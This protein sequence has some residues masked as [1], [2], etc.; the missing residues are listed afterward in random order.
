MISYQ[1]FL[2]LLSIFDV[3]WGRRSKIFHGIKDGGARAVAINDPSKAISYHGNTIFNVNDPSNE[4]DGGHEHNADA[5]FYDDSTTHIGGSDLQTIIEI[6]NETPGTPGPPGPPGPPGEDGAPGADGHSPVLT[7]ISDQI[8]IDGSV[9]GPHLTGPPGDPASN[10]H[11]GVFIT[12]ITPTGAGNVG[13]KV[14]SSDGVVLE[15]CVSD[16]TAITVSVLAIT[17]HTNYKPVVTV[18]GLPVTLTAFSDKPLFTGSIAITLTGTTVTAV[19]EDG[20]THVT[21]VT[22]DV[23]PNIVSAVFTGG[24][25]GSQTELKLGDTFNLHVVSSVPII[26]IE[27]SDYGAY[28]SQNFTVSGTDNTITGVIANRGTTVQSLGAKIRV[29]KSTGSWSSYY[30]TEND[31][32]VD[33][34]NL[35][36]LNNLY[37]SLAIGTITYPG[38]QQAL[39]NSETATVANTASSYNTIVY[40]SP[41]GDIS[42]ANT[43]TF[44]NPKTVTRIGG[45]YN[46]STNNFRVTANRSANNATTTVQG[47]VKIAN[48]ACTV[49]ITTPYSRLQSGGN[50]GTSAQNYTITVT[51]SQN[52]LQAPTL[53]AGM[54]TWQ[55]SGFTGSGTTWTRALQITDVMAKGSYSFSSLSAFNLAGIETTS[56]NSGSTYTIG[57]FVARNITLAAFANEAAMNVAATDYTKVTLSWSFK[58]S[59]TIRSP[60][61]STPP[62]V[63][64]WCLVALSTNPTTIRLL[65]TSATNSCSQASTITIQESV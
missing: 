22:A 47:L 42:I 23:S 40:D 18:N 24:Y 35:V 15:S 63:D 59:L 27:V 46:V 56:I 44:E 30:L 36:K 6:L 9:T 21:T 31:G 11:G 64:N 61:N 14:T 53:A 20:A 12:D 51:A 38:S 2:K 1:K 57:G 52:L 54:G 13:S 17:G 7:W 65:D 58:P 3:F 28:S 62:V 29:Q 60:L 45:S 32:S 50:D 33:G 5:I 26:K 37:P 25:P 41:N 19:H 55:G 48:T 4:A 34:T 43:T 16:T 39:K 10:I 49:N 8:A